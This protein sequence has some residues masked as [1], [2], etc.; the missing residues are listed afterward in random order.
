MAAFAAYDCGHHL[1]VWRRMEGD[2]WKIT[3]TIQ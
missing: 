1:P 3:R 2:L